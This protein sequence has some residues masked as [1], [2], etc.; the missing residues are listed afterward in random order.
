M[1]LYKEAEQ[2][3]RQL[4]NLNDLHA[5]LGNQALIM[6]NLGKL[7]EAMTLHKEEEQ[8]CRQLGKKHGMACSLINQAVCFMEMGRVQESLT[9]AKEAYRLAC[10]H[11]Y[12]DLANRIESI[13]NF[14]HQSAQQ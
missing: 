13:L 14:L 11:G 1:L 12:N 7:V 3:C 10:D 8:L 9:L 6:A 5:I 4:G 2:I